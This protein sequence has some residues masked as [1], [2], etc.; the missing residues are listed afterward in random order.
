VKGAKLLAHT[1]VYG[2]EGAATSGQSR[3]RDERAIRF[4]KH[5]IW[6][7]LKNSSVAAT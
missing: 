1:E 4:W 7:E 6:P 5:K 2:L 3:E